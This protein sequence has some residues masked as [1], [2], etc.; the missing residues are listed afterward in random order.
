MGVKGVRLQSDPVNNP[1]VSGS[2]WTEAAPARK[3]SLRA[4]ARAR[5]QAGEGRKRGHE[6]VRLE[7]HRIT[8]FHCLRSSLTTKVDTNTAAAPIR[9]GYRR[10]LT[11]VKE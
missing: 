10:L 7:L 3:V 4:P 11:F 5:K 2:G 1:G 8:S 6:G 9:G